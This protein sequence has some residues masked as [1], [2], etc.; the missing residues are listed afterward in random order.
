MTSPP[1]HNDFFNTVMNKAH[2][3]NVPAQNKHDVSLDSQATHIPDDSSI[4]A[5]DIGCPLVPIRDEPI[6]SRGRIVPTSIDSLVNHRRP[7]A[8]VLPDPSL[9]Y[10]EEMGPPP[11][12]LL[13]DKYRTA[14]SVALETLRSHGQL[15]DKTP[16]TSDLADRSF[17]QPAFQEATAEFAEYAVKCMPGYLQNPSGL[18]TKRGRDGDEALDIVRPRSPK[19]VRSERPP[20]E[21]ARPALASRAN[22]MLSEEALKDHPALRLLGD[23]WHDIHSQMGF[24]ETTTET[25]G[26][27]QRQD[28]MYHST[29]RILSR[30]A[31]EH[32]GEVRDDITEALL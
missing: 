7:N 18:R 10:V 5:I 29:S 23:G 11:R 8:S 28:A 4:P 31:M 19:R 1:V 16:S 9:T 2:S 17:N 27:E 30:I 32:L 20:V 3:I 26:D 22:A 24:A 15:Y 25:P 21:V 12:N 13:A 6:F 14:R